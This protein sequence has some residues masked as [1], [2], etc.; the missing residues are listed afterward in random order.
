MPD[1]CREIDCYRS[2]LKALAR[3]LPARSQALYGD[4][5]ARTYDAQLLEILGTSGKRGVRGQMPGL[6]ADAGTALVLEWVDV[7]RG[8]WI[9]PLRFAG[10]AL[11]A[12]GALWSLVALASLGDARWAAAVLD[13]SLP[14]TVTLML[15]L[16]LL[17]LV[18]SRVGAGPDRR[19]EGRTMLRASAAST[20]VAWFILTCHIAP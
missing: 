11:I 14:V 15:G 16:P 13:Y 8:T 4:E 1:T 17:S 9:S 6:L 20:V 18:A 3:M 5:L 2:L 10:M 7:W 19:R 12:A